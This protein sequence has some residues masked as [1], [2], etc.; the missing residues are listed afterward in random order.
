M[1]SF[2]DLPSAVRRARYSCDRGSRRRRLSAATCRHCVLDGAVGTLRTAC[3]AD[4][5]AGYS[6]SHC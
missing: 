2:L 1:A 4:S 6:G 5:V 3:P